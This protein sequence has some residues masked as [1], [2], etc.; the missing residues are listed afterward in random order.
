VFLVAN[1]L[2]WIL[3]YNKYRLFCSE[4]VSHPLMLLIVFGY[5]ITAVNNTYIIGV[6]TLKPIKRGEE[7][8]FDYNSVTEVFTESYGQFSPFVPK[9]FLKEEAGDLR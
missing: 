4:S 2:G 6:Y 7:L 3:V 1:S 9:I 5:R 8:T